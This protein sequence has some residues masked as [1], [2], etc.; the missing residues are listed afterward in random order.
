MLRRLK[1]LATLS[2]RQHAYLVK[3]VL[4]L[5]RARIDF[6]R[7]PAK[8]ILDALQ[9][10]ETARA[11]AIAA[12]PVDVAMLSWAIKAAAS[13]VPW[14]SDCLIQSMATD[15][16]LRRC[17]IVPDFR[18]GVSPCGEGTLLAHAWVELDGVVLTGGDDIGHYEVLIAS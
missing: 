10:K 11:T 3:A 12:Y 6:G 16:W 7:K 8:D 18:L 15:R 14:R 4:H 2:P 17:G 1:K 9:M 13:G 5:G